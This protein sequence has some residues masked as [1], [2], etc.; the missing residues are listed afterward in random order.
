MTREYHAWTDAEMWELFCWYVAKRRIGNITTKALD[1]GTQ[2]ANLSGQ[3]KR[4]R[5]TI[6]EIEARL[7]RTPEDRERRIRQLLA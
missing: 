5:E 1:L 7:G 2:P 4:A 3:I 6:A